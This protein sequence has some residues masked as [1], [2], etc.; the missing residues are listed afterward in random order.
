MRARNSFGP[1]SQGYCKRKPLNLE[2][3]TFCVLSVIVNKSMISELKTL[4][5]GI[6]NL[7]YL[8]WVSNGHTFDFL[9]N[10]LFLYRPSPYCIKVSFDKNYRYDAISIGL[11]SY[12]IELKSTVHKRVLEHLSKY[13][14][15]H[16][17]VNLLKTFIL[18]HLRTIVIL[19]VSLY[20][21]LSKTYVH[22]SIFSSINMTPST[23]QMR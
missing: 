7:D 10:P 5:W 19:N 13:K 16:V 8:I 23:P 2:K 14:L 15:N 9:L 17:N 11:I 21:H 18:L 6:L 3:T 1:L 20:K 22:Q 4:E 12:P